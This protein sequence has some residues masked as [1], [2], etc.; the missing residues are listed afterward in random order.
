MAITTKY[1]GPR[2]T[3]GSRV[4]ATGAQGSVYVDWASELGSEENHRAAFEKYMDKHYRGA[5]TA[6][7]AD[8]GVTW[9]DDGRGVWYYNHALATL[10]HVR[11]AITDGSFREA[12]NPYSKDWVRAVC[13]ALGEKDIPAPRAEGF[14]SSEPFEGSEGF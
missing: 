9:L 8:Y 10:R 6:N 14:E 5:V 7:P 2:D 1:I 4:K 3:R 13:H 11:A 12:G